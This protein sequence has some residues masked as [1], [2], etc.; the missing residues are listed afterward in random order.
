MQV[1]IGLDP[2]VLGLATLVP[3]FRL[4]SGGCYDDPIQGLKEYIYGSAVGA[5]TLG[6]ACVEGVAGAWTPV[7]TTNSAAGQVGG[8]GTRVGVA[9]ATAAVG[10][11]CWYQVFGTCAL[12][13]AGA[14]VIGT[15]LNTTATAGALDDDG[16]VGARPIMGAVFKTAAA[17]AAVSADARL[18]Y[19]TVGLTL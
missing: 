3:G 8:F 2:L 1:L 18:C 12:L 7:T 16:T 13:T 19:P 14:V 6:Q 5:Q 9:Q 10:Q 4:G 17:G 15:R 11:F